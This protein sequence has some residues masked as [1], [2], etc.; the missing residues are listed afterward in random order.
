MSNRKGYVLL[1]TLVLSAILSM[2]V[3]ALWS[4]VNLDL[5]IAGNTKRINQAKMAASSGLN[6]FIALGLRPEQLA[7]IS[8]EGGT[9]LSNTELTSKTFYN[10]RLEAICCDSERYIVKSTGYYK[11]GDKIIAEH[12]IRSSWVVQ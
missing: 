8:R 9:V 3:M 12:L 11:K 6:H 4:A 10:V 2:S 5:M 1:V 7:D